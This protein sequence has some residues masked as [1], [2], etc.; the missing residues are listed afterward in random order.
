VNVEINLAEL[1]AMHPRLPS[2]L[3]GLMVERA[4]LALERNH[5]APGASASWDWGKVVVNG[6]L[7]WPT[8]DLSAIGQHDVNRITE[9]GAEAVAL[10]LVHRHTRWR[11]VRR[12]QREEYAD[13]LL[14]DCSNGRR[15]LIA[16][17][18][19]GVDNGSI[20]SRVAEK[21]AQV[22]RSKDVDQRWVGVVG[23]ERPNACLCS[24]LNP[25]E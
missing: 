2:V 23:F 20:A 11:V 5:H 24:T 1:Q 7:V 25:A 22:S 18:V 13:W 4:A 9:D 3:A 12:L 10:V 16:F 6:H 8:P 19:S 14:E 17:E 21:L 15:E